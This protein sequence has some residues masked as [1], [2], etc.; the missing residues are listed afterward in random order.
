MTQ[1]IIAPAGSAAE[2]EEGLR[3][4]A[5]IFA[6]PA[7]GALDYKTMLWRNDPSFEPA[8]LVLG[9]TPQGELAG[10]IRIAPRMLRRQR[11]AI[12]TAC[13]SSVCVAAPLRGK[14]YS[15]QLMQRTLDICEQRGFEIALLLARRAA[16]HYYTR[17]GFWGASSYNR[18]TLSAS[19]GREPAGTPF[20][21][22]AMCEDEITLYASA[23][24]RSYANCF[25][26]FERDQAGWHFLL[27]RLRQQPGIE[28][29]AIARQSRTVG[30]LIRSHDALLEIGLGEALP[31]ADLA[32]A[33]PALSGGNL[34]LQ[35]DIPPQH[36][37]FPALHL[38]DVSLRSREC[39]Y[40]GHMLRILGGQAPD[41]PQTCARLGIATL[42][43]IQ[44]AD[45]RER[46]PFNLGYPDQV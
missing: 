27:R 22:R 4:A 1:L 15:V 44:E 20:E 6:V 35:I 24:E 29:L 5:G 25:G 37:L 13:I 11:Q 8:N 43:G 36:R 21:L 19:D 31:E 2:V 38:Y 45:A 46:L 40:G 39:S 23:Y 16:D 18:L 9:R 33:L 7:G 12:R 17:F 32:A 26:W 34:P 41:Y 14:G 30:Y 10:L 42:T 28:M 3:L